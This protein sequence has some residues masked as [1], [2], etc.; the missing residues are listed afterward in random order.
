M[1]YHYCQ[2]TG[3]GQHVDV[4]ICEI[5]LNF[6]GSTAPFAFMLKENLKRCG[7]YRTGTAGGA[8]I[9]LLWPCKDGFVVYAVIGTPSGARSNMGLLEVMD[10]EGFGEALK[11][12]N[13]DGFD[14][15]T[16]TQETQS[17]VED[18]VAPFILSHTKDEL[19][20]IALE[21]RVMLLP[22]NT[23]AELQDYSQF[24]SRELWVEVEHRELD[25]TITYPGSFIKY[26]EGN[27]AVRYRAPLIGEHNEEIY[28][29]EL[30]FTKEEL[31][32]MKAAA[33]I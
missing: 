23:P 2:E 29:G 21:K 1:A 8:L 13:W 33:I 17:C 5:L 11:S 7:S 25:T 9:R 31:V 27:C 22:V 12:F 18:A 26:A 3:E 20:K 10:K 15:S 19:L 14:R 32:L 4:S 6:S 30:G 16:A 24:K 28:I